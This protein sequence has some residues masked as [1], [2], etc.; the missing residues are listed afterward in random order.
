[1]IFD[2]QRFS[3]HDGP[4][5]RTVVFLKG[6][7]LRCQWCS[8]PESQQRDAEILFDARRCI[9]CRSCLAPQFGGAM[10]EVAGAIVPDRSR[11]VP[12]GLA[13]VC[14]TRALRVAGREASVDTLVTEVTQ[15]TAFF[16]KSGGGVT[17]SG[18]EPLDQVEFLEACVRA[19]SARGVSVAVESCLAVEPE[20][21]AKLLAYPL[22]WLVDLKHVDAEAYLYQT[23]GH[24]DQAL[25]N[26]RTLARSTARITYRIPVIPGFNEGDADRT[27]LLDFLGSLER[28]STD[29]VRVDLLAYHELAAGKYAQLGRPHP[30]TRGRLVPGVMDAWRD[31]A[32]ARG[33][34]VNVGGR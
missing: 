13:T 3:T 8:N 32:Q 22:D 27:K 20:A 24:V 29:A 10:R 2:V 11:P 25:N 26:L 14:P 1:M 16:T 9:A 18:G 30:Y 23:S 12:P 21:L 19:L 34:S 5:I 33:F 7:S 6:C 28:V 4:G 17:F 31:D 15:D